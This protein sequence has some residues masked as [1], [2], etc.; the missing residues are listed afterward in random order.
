ML[1]LSIQCTRFER[2]YSSCTGRS[3]E[4][5]CSSSGGAQEKRNTGWNSGNHGF[6][7]LNPPPFLNATVLFCNFF[8]NLTLCMTKLGLLTLSFPDFTDISNTLQISGFGK[9]FKDP[10]C[11]MKQPAKNR[12]FR[13]WSLTGSLILFRN[14]RFRAKTSCLRTVREPPPTL[15]PYTQ[16]LTHQFFL[17]KQENNHGVQFTAFQ[18]LKPQ[19]GTEI[20]KSVEIRF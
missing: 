2:N 16:T 18:V 5:L 3:S 15:D 10:T 12:W 8:F 13:A 1:N 19:Y 20:S 4:N 7:S 17:W 14:H 9:F 11:F 6:L